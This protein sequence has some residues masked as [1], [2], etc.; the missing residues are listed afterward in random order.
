MCSDWCRVQASTQQ[1]L[2]PQPHAAQPSTQRS[3]NRKEWSASSEPAGRGADQAADR[4][5]KLR[6]VVSL[7]DMKAGNCSRCSRS[8]LTTSL[9]PML[10][11]RCFPS[12]ALTPSRSYTLTLSGTHCG[13][14]G[15]SGALSLS[16][17]RTLCGTHGGSVAVELGTGVIDSEDLFQLSMVSTGGKWT[18]ER[19][20]KLA[21]RLGANAAGRASQPV[22]P[23]IQDP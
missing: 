5:H 12:H 17:P 2:A 7:F 22:R 14:L 15:R 1:H 23:V 4:A 11:L 21:S 16:D 10:S 20:Q 8:P 19:N 18:P 13:W 6:V 9:P 3:V